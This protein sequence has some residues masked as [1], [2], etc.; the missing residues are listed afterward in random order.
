MSDARFFECNSPDVIFEEFGDETILINLKTGSYY[1]VSSVGILVWALIQSRVAVEELARWVGQ[2]FPGDRDQIDDAIRDFVGQLA[3]EELIRS[4]PAG[5]PLG[6]VLATVR[7]PA[8][9]DQAFKPPVLAK[10][11]DMAEMLLLDPVHEVSEQGWPSPR[12]TV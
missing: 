10:Y 11:D 6:E 12:P 4:V 9:D 7:L 1:S 8:G 2:R 3:Q 5:R